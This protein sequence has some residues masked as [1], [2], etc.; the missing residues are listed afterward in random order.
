MIASRPALQMSCLNVM[1]RGNSKR[2]RSPSPATS[3]SSSLGDPSSRSPTPPPAPKY[4]RSLP[5][6]TD[7]Y[8]C[9][10]PPTCSQPSTST[11]YASPADLDRHQA[12]F[13]TW[14]CRTPIRNK[15]GDRPLLRLPLPDDAGSSVPETF[16]SRRG[17]WE[18]MECGKVFPD[19][20]MLN[21]VSEVPSCM[22]KAEGTLR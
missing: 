18:W 21:L 14:V 6:T 12:I 4:H 7:A 22:G 3:S 11:S 9:N 20:R 1:E 17:Q 16:V 2:P 15:Q 8:T 5:L 10:L 13:H 19:E